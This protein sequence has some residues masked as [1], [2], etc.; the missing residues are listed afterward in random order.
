[1]ISF[2][3]NAFGTLNII[4]RLLLHRRSVIA[5]CGRRNALAEYLLRIS[6]ILLES[7]AINLPLGLMSIIGLAVH[8]DYTALI[9]QVLA[10]GQVRLAPVYLEEEYLWLI[11][12]FVL[13]H[14]FYLSG[15]PSCKE[16][17]YFGTQPIGRK[18]RPT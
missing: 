6:S 10:P 17:N 9:C 16:K 5:A 13:E 3:L 15:L 8:A 11:V 1:M 7:A 18:T 14:C 2:I 12:L 4:I